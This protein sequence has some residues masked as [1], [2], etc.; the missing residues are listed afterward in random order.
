M[1]IVPLRNFFSHHSVFTFACVLWTGVVITG[2][3]RRL[4]EVGFDYSSLSWGTFVLFHSSC[5]A[6]SL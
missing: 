6:F 3:F 4:D 1:E 5:G 2:C